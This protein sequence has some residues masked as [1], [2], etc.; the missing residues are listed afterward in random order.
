MLNVN[1]GLIKLSN[2]SL[3]KLK[4]AI[5]E[6]T[7]NIANGDTVILGASNVNLG[8]KALITAV[9]VKIL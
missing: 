5:L 7:V 1:G 4:K 9:T 8:G 6:T 3:S 2:F